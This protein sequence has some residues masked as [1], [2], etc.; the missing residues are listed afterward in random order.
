MARRQMSVQIE[1]EQWMEEML[2]QCSE[3]LQPHASTANNIS[4]EPFHQSLD[5]VLKNEAV[6][7]VSELS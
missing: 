1:Q 3:Q 5:A 6:V 4:G 7:V 2:R